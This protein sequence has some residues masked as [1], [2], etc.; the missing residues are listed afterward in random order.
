ML[1]KSVK[2]LENVSE[3][4]PQAERIKEYSLKMC[5]KQLQILRVRLDQLK[6]DLMKMKIKTKII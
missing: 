3:P 1:S 5:N 6:L 2:S 4:P